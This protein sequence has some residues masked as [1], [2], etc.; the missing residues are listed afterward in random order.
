MSG[1]E[2]EPIRK[3]RPHCTFMYPMYAVMSTDSHFLS[4]FRRKKIWKT[5]VLQNYSELYDILLIRIQTENCFP[6]P[7]LNEKRKLK[8]SEI[9]YIPVYKIMILR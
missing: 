2:M 6:M 9:K 1:S 5:G 7:R 4:F 8:I 3:W